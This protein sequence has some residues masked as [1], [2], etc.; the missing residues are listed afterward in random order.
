MLRKPDK[1]FRPDNRGREMLFK[2]GI[3]AF[4]IHWQVASID[5]GGNAVFFRFRDMI[6]IAQFQLLNPAR[7]I[8]HFL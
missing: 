1:A 8:T 3:K 5:K 7:C 6:L 2:E 4:R